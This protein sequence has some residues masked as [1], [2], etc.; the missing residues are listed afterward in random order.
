MNESLTFHSALLVRL[1]WGSEIRLRNTKQNLLS[2]FGWHL[3][4]QEANVYE[5]C[6]GHI[7]HAWLKG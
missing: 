1:D 5:A 2:I 7:L 3:A 4:K 6:A